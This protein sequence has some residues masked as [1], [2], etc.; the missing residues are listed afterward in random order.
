MAIM[1]SLTS[2]R[3]VRESVEDYGMVI[4]DECHHVSAPSF[5]QILKRVHAK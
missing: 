4:V 5:E 3:E 1:Q 2:E